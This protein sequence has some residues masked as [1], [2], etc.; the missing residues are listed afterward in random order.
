[1][2][3]YSTIGAGCSSLGLLQ[4]RLLLQ[5]CSS[6]LD[7]VDSILADCD[8][9][10]RSKVRGMRSAIRC[11]RCLKATRGA[12]FNPF[13]GRTARTSFSCHLGHHQRLFSRAFQASFHAALCFALQQPVGLLLFDQVFEHSEEHLFGVVFDQSITAVVLH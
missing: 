10:N 6:K 7:S 3:F 5:A 11:S 4:S 9:L 8:F 2:R 12:T 1:V 13:V